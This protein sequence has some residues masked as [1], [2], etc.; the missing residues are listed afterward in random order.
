MRACLATGEPFDTK[1]AS[2]GEW[3]IT[4]G[5]STGKSTSD[6]LGNIVSGMDRVSTSKTKQAESSIAEKRLLE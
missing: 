2:V 6:A 3:R 1:L 4:G 5:C